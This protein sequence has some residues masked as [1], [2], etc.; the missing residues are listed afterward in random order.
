[1]Q[2]WHSSK[3]ETRELQTQGC[4]ELE[5]RF[6]LAVYSIRWSETAESIKKKVTSNYFSAS[7][8]FGFF[9]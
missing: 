8:C 7:N 2:K 6:F 1:M 9:L 5:L 3:R 4:A